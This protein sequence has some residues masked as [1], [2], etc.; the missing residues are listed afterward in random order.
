MK[1]LI[2]KE[3]KESL[4]DLNYYDESLKI[5]ISTPKNKNFGDL[6]SN[7]ALLLSKKLKKPTLIEC[8]KNLLNSPYFNR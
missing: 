3:L 5:S 7:I 2:I 4:I 1:N 6:S 8:G